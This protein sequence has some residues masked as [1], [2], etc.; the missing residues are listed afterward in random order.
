MASEVPRGVLHL[1]V[2]LIAKLVRWITVHQLSSKL[3]LVLEK[4]WLNIEKYFTS[5]V[6]QFPRKGVETLRD[7]CRNDKLRA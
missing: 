2:F 5:Q 3:L 7:E 4:S 1:C 6:K